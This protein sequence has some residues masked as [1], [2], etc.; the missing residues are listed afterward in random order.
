MQRDVGKRTPL[1]EDRLAANEGVVGEFCPDGTVECC[2][3]IEA[4]CTFLGDIG[5][6]HIARRGLQQ[7]TH[8]EGRDARVGLQH[9]RCRATDH[10]RRHAGA[11]QFELRLGAESDDEFRV[12]VRQCPGAQQAPH[13]VPWRYEV[14]LEDVVD[15][16]GAS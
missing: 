11:A 14:W 2:D 12:L 8:P 10:R 3:D 15:V 7:H 6:R 1:R 5:Q 13:A 16:G 4:P 9:Q